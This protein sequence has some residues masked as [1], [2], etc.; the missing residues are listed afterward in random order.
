MNTLETTPCTHCGSCMY[1]L[2]FERIPSLG[3]R[4]CCKRGSRNVFCVS[5][6]KRFNWSDQALS[7]LTTA[8]NYVGVHQRTCNAGTGTNAHN[9]SA[10]IA[11]NSA[12]R[13]RLEGGSVGDNMGNELGDKLGEDFGNDLG[14]DMGDV[15]TDQ[16]MNTTPSFLNYPRHQPLPPQERATPFLPVPEYLDTDF[17][18]ALVASGASTELINKY[19]IHRQPPVN[20]TQLNDAGIMDWEERELNA[21]ERPNFFQRIPN[22]PVVYPSL[23]DAL[24]EENGIFALFPQF[25]GLRGT[26]REQTSNLLVQMTIMVLDGKPMTQQKQSGFA[27]TSAALVQLMN[28][29]INKHKNILA[30]LEASNKL[31]QQS[32][33][34]MNSNSAGKCAATATYASG[35]TEQIEDA[36]EKITASRQYIHQLEFVL[37]HLP[38][39][40]QAMRAMISGSG[41]ISVKTLLA[42]AEHS[43]VKR[44]KYY[45][46]PT[47]IWLR[48]MFHR[49]IR[50]NFLGCGVSPEIWT[51][52]CKE[53]CTRIL[54]K[55]LQQSSIDNGQK[56]QTQSYFEKMLGA[57]T[58]TAPSGSTYT[59]LDASYA[60][61]QYY[62]SCILSEATNDSAYGAT[63][64][65]ILKKME[66]NVL[67]GVIWKTGVAFSARELW[68][69]HSEG[70]KYLLNISGDWR[71]DIESHTSSTNQSGQ[72][73]VEKVNINRHRGAELFDALH[74]T[75][76]I[77]PK[78]DDEEG[79]AKI[80]QINAQDQC[81]LRSGCSMFH[82]G[83][84]CF[85]NV[86]CLLTDY[87]ADMPE[88]ASLLQLSSRIKGKENPMP[89]RISNVPRSEL[90]A[91]ILSVDGDLQRLGTE[92]TVAYQTDVLNRCVQTWHTRTSETEK[93]IAATIKQELKHAGFNNK[94]FYAV[95]GHAERIEREHNGTTVPV[96]RNADLNQQIQMHKHQLLEATK[97][98]GPNATAAAVKNKIKV[99]SSN[100]SKATTELAAHKASTTLLGPAIWQTLDGKLERLTVALFHMMFLG[101]TKN[102]HKTFF[103]VGLKKMH[104]GTLFDQLMQIAVQQFRVGNGAS[105]GNG[106]RTTTN[107]RTQLP[108]WSRFPEW[109]ARP[110]WNGS[111]WLMWSRVM[112]IIVGPVLDV[113]ISVRAGRFR[114]VMD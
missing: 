74:G 41:K 51:E 42:D 30:S 4:T 104:L 60:E 19:N 94:K 34:L 10:H 101:I 5:C 107:Q 68:K 18:A 2:V 36:T 16:Q 7:T 29:G 90:W 75:K 84:D 93:K 102:I 28:T 15:D 37:S 59:E 67:T 112:P 14:D 1:T 70:G 95:V 26:V 11:S 72:V 103:G 48:Y 97:E 83:L 92:H 114:K 47:S 106:N 99:I 32:V 9:Y 49:G 58:H 38:R 45:L 64:V 43:L 17:I 76:L 100:L 3:R 82:S 39:D 12:K 86:K 109:R 78:K 23:I 111:D 46:C 65:Q 87:Q 53:G 81:F 24:L 13:R 6:Q 22:L 8:R 88:N 62:L 98:L 33:D 35:A 91:Q 57:V 96:T 44:G 31:L 27:S 77:G 61:L 40:M 69:Q 20:E 71:D 80:E 89:G 73:K 113:C 85:V 54:L 79:L 56:A 66:T 21:N 55:L 63:S 52:S 108:E 25:Q 105:T 110:N 50:M